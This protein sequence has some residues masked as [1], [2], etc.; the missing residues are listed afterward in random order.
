M[1]FF[2]LTVLG[3]L[4]SSQVRLAHLALSEPTHTP[5]KQIYI[6]THVPPWERTIK[7]T[8]RKIINMSYNKYRL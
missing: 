6:V 5:Q 8:E 1:A 4:E 3:I 2:S 7:P